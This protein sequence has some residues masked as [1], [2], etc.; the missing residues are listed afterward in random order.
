MVKWHNK[1]PAVFR[2]WDQAGY[3]WGLPMSLARTI[4]VLGWLPAPH[5]SLCHEVQ[6]F[7]GRLHRQN[8]RSKRQTYKGVFVAFD[9]EIAYRLFDGNLCLEGRFC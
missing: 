3:E 2:L 7:L 8:W 6:S 9:L 4:S 5:W 1:G